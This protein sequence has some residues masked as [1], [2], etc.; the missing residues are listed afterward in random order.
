MAKGQQTAVNAP[1]G[2][3]APEP[4]RSLNLSTGLVTENAPSPPS[5]SAPA[6][7]QVP[8][9]IS[10][11]FDAANAEF[12]PPA[13]M[14]AQGLPPA[15]PSQFRSDPPTDP[16]Q[17]SDVANLESRLGEIIQGMERRELKREEEH[18]RVM[19]ER[20]LEHQMQVFELQQRAPANPEAL[21]PILRGDPDGSI[22]RRE[23]ME[24][25]D[26][27]R[28]DAVQMQVQG[29][30]SSWN[31]SSQQEAEILTRYPRVSIMPEPQKTL[32]IRQ[33]AGILWP[34]GQAQAPA[35]PGTPA[36][37]PSGKGPEPR[38]SSRR[39]IPAPEGTGTPPSAQDYDAPVNAL[40]QAKAEYERAQKI[41]NPKERTDALRAITEKIIR[42]QGG[43]MESFVK[44]GFVAQ[45]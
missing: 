25:L 4:T 6:P 5:P 39:T 19:A 33:Y 16:Q 13:P 15:A 2:G 29:V 26:N 24:F 11:S 34:A 20:E 17:A 12:A 23:M 35:A 7:I 32:I 36:P 9:R 31:V 37:S 14:P 3:G 8:P 44:G 1:Y 38:P 45:G 21:P 41:A 40:Q 28:Q 10:S 30:R 42:L 18:R 22:T 27:V 43:D